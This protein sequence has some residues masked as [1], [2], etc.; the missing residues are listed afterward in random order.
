MACLA[1]VL[2]EACVQV[3]RPHPLVAA[4]PRPVGFICDRSS[5]RLPRNA[6]C[7]A[8]IFY[9]AL[10]SWMFG[11]VRLAD[12]FETKTREQDTAAVVSST[13]GGERRGGSSSWGAEESAEGVRFPPYQPG[14]PGGRGLLHR[15]AASR[16]CLA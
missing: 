6:T 16:D 1:H 5:R 15:R 3:P 8:V 12:M 4:A 14:R 11:A 10:G 2:R 7:R 13:R 9:A